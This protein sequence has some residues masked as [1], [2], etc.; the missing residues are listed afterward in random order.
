MEYPCAAPGVQLLNIKKQLLPAELEG[1]QGVVT[2]VSPQTQGSAPLS[3]SFS[4]GI[5]GSLL[6]LAT[7]L[8]GDRWQIPQL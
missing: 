3:P 7:P 1:R 4:W 5:L 2:F 6:T 8:L